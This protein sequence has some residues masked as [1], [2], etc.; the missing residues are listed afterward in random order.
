MRLGLGVL[1]LVSALMLG[2]AAPA[3]AATAFTT[4]YCDKDYGCSSTAHFRAASG[5]IND[6]RVEAAGQDGAIVFRDQTA[7]L[8]AGDGC[9]SVGAGAVLCGTPGREAPGSVVAVRVELGDRADR[10]D[11]QTGDAVLGRVYGGPGKDE[12][13]APGPHRLVGGRGDDRLSGDAET[14]VSYQGRVGAV[15]VDL[16]AG[17][18][19][20]SSGEQDTLNGITSVIGGSGDDR[21]IG[22]GADNQLDGEAGDDHIS[23]AGGND[24]LNAGSG[25][26]LLTGGPGKD[27]LDPGSRG[28]PGIDDQADVLRCGSGK[29]AVSE[30][31]LRDFAEA[32]CEKVWVVDTVEPLELTPRL[33]SLEGRVV[34]LDEDCLCT[35]I[36]RLRDIRTG[37]LLGHTKTGP[38]RG[39]A[40]LRLNAAGRRTLRQRR[41]IPVRIE[42]RWGARPLTGVRTVLSLSTP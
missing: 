1:G 14:T 12:L 27:E 30:V 16:L 29:D 6:V 38:A 33:S 20:L 19:A 2:G 5:E 35:L 7:T 18:A 22:D 40:E 4:S 21:L 41:R 31:D 25:A 11:L 23:G 24:Q 37:M 42:V 3:G 26:D 8:V 36:L 34:A 39:R 10:V 17:R 28:G 32:S 9:T 15:R 13:S